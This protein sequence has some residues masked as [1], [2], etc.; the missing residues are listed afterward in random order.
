MM[1]KRLLITTGLVILL[2][3]VFAIGVNVTKDHPASLETPKSA[4]GAL[5][6]AD[7]DCASQFLCSS[8]VCVSR[9]AANRAVDRGGALKTKKEEADAL[10]NLV[11]ERS[12]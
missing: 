8:N 9:S 1:I 4:E 11:I 12:P 6:F 2:L 3:A 5:C 7:D 10:P